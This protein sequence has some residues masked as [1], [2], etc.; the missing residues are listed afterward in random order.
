[1]KWHSSFS[2]FL[3][4]SLFSPPPFLWGKGYLI[5]IAEDFLVTVQ[6]R[7]FNVWILISIIWPWQPKIEHFKISVWF[8]HV[9]RRT[10]W[11]PASYHCPI[12]PWGWCIVQYFKIW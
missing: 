3:S 2:L 12:K 6:N 10:V 8:M 11:I 4:L 7:Y 9:R 5:K 1:M